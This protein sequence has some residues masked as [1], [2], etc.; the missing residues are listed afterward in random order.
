MLPFADKWHF[1]RR[2]FLH[3]THHRA[4]MSAVAIA[5][6]AAAE[7]GLNGVAV[8]DAQHPDDDATGALLVLLYLELAVL[9][10]ELVR[11]VLVQHEREHLF[12]E[13]L[14]GLPL[15]LAA[16]DEHVVLPRMGV[17]VTVHDHA[18]VLEQALNHR[19]GVPNGRVC[20]ADHGPVLAVQVL[21]GQRAA[22]VAHDDAVR[23]EHRDQFEDELVPQL[24]G[25]ER[26]ARYK[27]HQALHHPRGGRLAGVDTCRHNDGL[28]LLW[29]ETNWRD[30][31]GGKLFEKDSS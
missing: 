3:L 19:L 6:R 8:R 9:E 5:E 17:H 14:L 15:V 28:F 26:V 21:A 24:F 27:V 10:R 25:D 31:N 20:L 23:I 30:G 29:R 7:R 11:H 2:G 4:E 13:L 1:P 12:G 18:A 16:V 22:R